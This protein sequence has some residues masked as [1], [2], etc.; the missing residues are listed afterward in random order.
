M[1]QCEATPCV[2]E[3]G[4]NECARAERIEASDREGLI[5]CA[6][7]A[8][9]LPT[10]VWL[11]VATFCATDTLRTLETTGMDLLKLVRADFTDSIWRRRFDMAA[12]AL[13]AVLKGTGRDLCRLFESR[14]RATHLDEG[15]VGRLVEE[16]H[17]KAL[18]GVNCWHGLPSLVRHPTVILVVDGVAGKLKWG[19]EDAYGERQKGR[20]LMWVLKEPRGPYYEEEL[21]TAKT[22]CYV[23]GDEK[24]VELWRD[25]SCHFEDVYE[26]EFG[27]SITEDN[28]R[29]SIFGFGGDFIS[30][31]RFE[32]FE[33][34]PHYF[35]AYVRAP[36]RKKERVDR[37]SLVCRL[38]FAPVE[39][40]R[41]DP[42][43][44]SYELM[45]ASVGY[46]IDGSDTI[47]DARTL[48]SLLACLLSPAHRLRGLN[49]Y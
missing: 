47:R 17:P 44:P 30:Q 4:V 31:R 21:A 40:W 42:N 13:S 6:T 23:V 46:R 35:D 27:N 7:R 5:E 43:E 25:G 20:Q 10:D 49:Y 22:S 38:Q 41:H 24:I 45:D 37:I 1:A 12:P 28:G 9:R 29:V 15:S 26:D 34:H 2:D 32:E 3:P 14:W 18:L 11:G 16:Y 39:P 33:T 19:G 48:G 8:P 36:G